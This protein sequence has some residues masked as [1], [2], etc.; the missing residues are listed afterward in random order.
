MTERCNTST[1]S[2]GGLFP[3]IRQNKLPRQ[4]FHESLRYPAIKCNYPFTIGSSPAWGQSPVEWVLGLLIVI[5]IGK[6][7]R[8][9]HLP[10]QEC[11][12]TAMNTF[13]SVTKPP[14]LMATL[15]VSDRVLAM[16]ISKIKILI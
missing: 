5:K 11:K 2:F 6:L 15:V 8:T 3:L 14:S 9:Y 4:C 16:K 7:E 13:T 10:F 12:K 1:N